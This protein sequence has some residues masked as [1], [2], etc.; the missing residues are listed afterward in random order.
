MSDLKLKDLGKLRQTYM[1]QGN[2]D[3]ACAQLIA[4]EYELE[5]AKV[6]AAQSFEHEAATP[7]V[8]TAMRKLNVTEYL[9]KYNVDALPAEVQVFAIGPAAVVFLPG[10][11]FVELGLAIKEASPFAYTFVV[12]LTYDDISYVPTKKA[13]GEGSYEVEIAWIKPGEGEK[14]VQ[15]A[16]KLLQRIKN[17]Q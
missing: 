7:A 15:T 8:R 9:R 4:T 2:N 12:E 14:M 10:E 11:N 13:F 6:I 17:N 5:E 3:T 16:V 1:M